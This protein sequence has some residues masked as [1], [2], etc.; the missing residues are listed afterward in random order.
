LA[1]RGPLAR[2]D[3]PGLYARA[4]A[5]LAQAPGGT[6]RCDVTG[7]APDAVAV[8]ALARLQLAARG[9]G[10]GVVLVGAS[11]NLLAV[12]DLVGLGAALPAEK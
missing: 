1:I 7:I 12:V 3:L 8:E 2:D 9:N 6:V 4:C 10:Q 11:A 5:L